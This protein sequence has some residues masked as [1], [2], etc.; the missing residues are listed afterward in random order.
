MTYSLG[1]A[2]LGVNLIGGGGEVLGK[3]RILAVLEGALAVGL[4]LGALVLALALV[5][6]LTLALDTLGARR[7]APGHALLGLLVAR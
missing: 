4:T 7:S 5:A 2:V 6:H 1:L 3:A